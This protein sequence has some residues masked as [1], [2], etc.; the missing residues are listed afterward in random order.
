M[1]ASRKGGRPRKPESEHAVRFSITM[2]PNLHAHL[3][4]MSRKN[5][6]PISNIIAAAVRLLIWHR[7]V[8][9]STKK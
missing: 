9:P 3:C 6:V 5:D 7:S 4:Q 8:A 2:A 1:G